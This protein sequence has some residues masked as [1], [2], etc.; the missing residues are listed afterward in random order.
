MRFAR[1]STRERAIRIGPLTCVLRSRHSHIRVQHGQAEALTRTPHADTCT[2]TSC[3]SWV[4][5]ICIYATES[6]HASLEPAVVHAGN[7]ACRSCGVRAG[8]NRASAAP[9]ARRRQI[10]H[11]CRAQAHH[12]CDGA[13][14]HSWSRC[15]PDPRR[16]AGLDRRVR[17]H[18]PALET[19]DRARHDFQHSVDIE[20]LHGHRD[21]ARGPARH[22]QS[23]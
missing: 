16:A 3:A 15:L 4:G 8:A 18:R 9:R 2:S 20:E 5:D 21:H 12:G 11:R 14:R 6:G 17:P 13:R 1:C 7:S 19:P 22:P 10:S 23:G